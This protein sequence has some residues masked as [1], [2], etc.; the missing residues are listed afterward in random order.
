LGISE[1]SLNISPSSFFLQF[2]SISIEV[3]GK[4]K[5]NSYPTDSNRII[6]Y[7]KIFMIVLWMERCGW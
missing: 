4:W 1:A 6:I 7:K 2:P 3:Q 5:K